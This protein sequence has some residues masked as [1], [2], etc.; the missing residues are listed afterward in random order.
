MQNTTTIP[1]FNY[2]V[3]SPKHQ[4]YRCIVA[5][6]DVIDKI[7][8]LDEFYK[9]FGYTH[10]IAKTGILADEFIWNEYVKD[11]RFEACMQMHIIEYLNNHSPKFR[12]LYGNQYEVLVNK[13]AEARE[14]RGFACTAC[15]FKAV[16]DD[17]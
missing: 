12:E 10:D 7:D 13:H 16:C 4:H 1:H 14:A 3:N 15:R 8:N 2:I 17:A 5:G 6:N 11:I 9:T